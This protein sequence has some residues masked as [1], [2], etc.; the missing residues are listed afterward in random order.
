MKDSRKIADV[1]QRGFFAGIAQGFEDHANSCVMAVDWI[2]KNIERTDESSAFVNVL[3][4]SAEY[5]SLMARDV[6]GHITIIAVVARSLYELN[7]QVRD[8]LESQKGLDRWF[9]ESITDKIQIFEGFLESETIGDTADGRHEIKN[10][11]KR[12]RDLREKYKLPEGR[13]SG[14]AQLASSLGL[15]KEHKSLYKVFSK[16]IHPSSYLVND[17]KSASSDENKDILRIMAQIYAGDTF[18]RVC[19]KLSVP[20][21]IR[22]GKS[23]HKTMI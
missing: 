3:T 23:S 17:Y 7:L 21:E 19:D 22:S 2:S 15:L 8:I 5:M 12:L 16:L 9:G 14:A 13:P 4:L 6:N 11:I 18:S 10:E 1:L 20:E